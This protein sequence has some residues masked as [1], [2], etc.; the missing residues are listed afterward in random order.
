MAGHIFP[1]NR[2]DRY[3]HV[4]AKIAAMSWD[5]KVKINHQRRLNLD[6]LDGFSNDFVHVPFGRLRIKCKGLISVINRR[7]WVKNKEE[8]FLEES[9]VMLL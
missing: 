3:A 9:I 5:Q 7:L 8:D 2:H 6:F 4:A 1:S